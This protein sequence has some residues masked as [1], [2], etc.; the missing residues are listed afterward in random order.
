MY[1]GTIQIQKQQFNAVYLKLRESLKFIFLKKLLPIHQLLAYKMEQRLLVLLL[2]VVK[3]L[4]VQLQLRKP[5]VSLL[6][7]IILQFGRQMESKLLQEQISLRKLFLH[8]QQHYMTFHIQ[9][10]Q[11]VVQVSQVLP[12]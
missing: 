11:L 3:V 5:G 1:T 6:L 2:L 12:K 4:P 8:R 9:I 10:K 7:R